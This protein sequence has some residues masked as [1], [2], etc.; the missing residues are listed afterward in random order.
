MY[1]D[2]NAFNHWLIEIHL[3]LSCVLLNDSQRRPPDQEEV[4]YSA[5][6]LH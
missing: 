4:I 3:T 2:V 6:K 5:V 1:H